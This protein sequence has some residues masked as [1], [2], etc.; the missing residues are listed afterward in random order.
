MSCICNVVPSSQDFCK[1]DEMIRKFACCLCREN[2]VLQ[3]W[4]LIWLQLAPTRPD[5]KNG[6]EEHPKE[7]F[8][9]IHRCVDCDFPTPFQFHGDA[10]RQKWSCKLKISRYLSGNS[11]GDHLR[12]GV[13]Q[14]RPF[15][16]S[17]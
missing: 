16:I 6:V 10:S 13:T 12:S 4:D 5:F 8:Q 3:P 14:V 7:G 2:Q 9:I 15:L 1:Y 17:N 11:S